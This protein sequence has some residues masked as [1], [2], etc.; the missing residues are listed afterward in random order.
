MF[1]PVTLQRFQLV[2]EFGRDLSHGVGFVFAVA[3]KL[4]NA[5]ERAGL[6]LNSLTA[7][8]AQNAHVRVEPRID[9]EILF[10]REVIITD[11]F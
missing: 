6:P 5:F 7:A 2:F 1:S 10:R 11:H 3:D 4:A 9:S 8:A